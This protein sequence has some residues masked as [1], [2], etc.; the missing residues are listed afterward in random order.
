ML[1][2]VSVFDKGVYIRSNLVFISCRCL[3]ELQFVSL[4]RP[5]A[6]LV[7]LNTLDSEMSDEVILPQELF[8]QTNSGREILIIG[9]R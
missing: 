1:F 8:E 6:S 9:A 7:A 2:I 4:P 3:L 5:E